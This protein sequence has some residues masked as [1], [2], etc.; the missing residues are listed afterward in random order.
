MLHKLHLTDN[1]LLNLALVCYLGNW[2]ANAQAVPDEEPHPKLDMILQ[3]VY[4]LAKEDHLK[5]MK[6]T[7][8]S[9]RYNCV[10][11]DDINSSAYDIIQEYDEQT[12]FESLAHFL[13]ERDI[14][15]T[16]VSDESMDEEQL[17]ELEVK[18]YDAYVEEFSK[19]G[20][21][22]LFVSPKT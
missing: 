2:I 8:D 19:Y 21:D 12:M 18:N 10:E 15:T 6:V 22:R 5:G 9:G 1:E 20:L 4:K 17:F 16:V 7:Y 11:H 14:R 13:A 3:K